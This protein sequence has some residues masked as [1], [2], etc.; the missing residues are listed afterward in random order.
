MTKKS[1]KSPH[2]QS[3]P[4]VI[5]LPYFGTVSHKLQRL[6][7]KQANIDVVLRRSHT[8][9]NTIKATIQPQ[10]RTIRKT[11]RCCFR[12]Q[13][14]KCVLSLLLSVLYA[15]CCQVR[16]TSG[17]DVFLV[18]ALPS[19][20]V[21]DHYCAYTSRCQAYHWDATTR[22]CQLHSTQPTTS[23]TG[24][25]NYKPHVGQCGQ[26][27]CAQTETC[28]PVQAAT[29][30]ICLAT[31]STTS[32]SA[33]TASPSSAT[34]VP[35]V[36]TTTNT[37]PSET[38]TSFV[39]STTPTASTS[40]PTTT[41]TTT[42]SPAT[43]AN[44][45][46][47][48]TTGVPAVTTTTYA[49]QIATITSVV[50]STT[51]TT[52][53]TTTNPTTSLTTTTSSPATTANPSTLT[54]TAV[55]VV[56]TTIYASQNAT[57]TSI[58]SSTTTTIG[59]TTTSPTTSLTTTTSSPTT[60]SIITTPTTI[61]TTSTPTTTSTT[62]APT[63]TSTTTTA[64]PTT[65][66]TTTTTTTATTTTT[67]P[68]TTTTSGPVYRGCYIDD[69]NRVLPHEHLIDTTTMTIELCRI[70]CTE[71]G[72]SFFGLEV[73]VE[74]LCGHTITSGYTKVLDNKCDRPCAADPANTC[75]GEWKIAIYEV[76]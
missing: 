75:G 28:V 19:Q 4:F 66:S 68:T 10:A 62:P 50:S 74:C 31:T 15:V 59:T 41:L 3:T 32:S 5:S 21:C 39:S 64:T 57:I 46:T 61:P 7:K 44:P 17:A 13:D 35:P 11:C 72:Y 45:S 47:L 14:M 20:R 60:S 69:S 40:S 27:Q 25:T 52:G 37:S 71:K 55:P 24:F 48:T 29:A 8:I 49:S 67:T 18:K 22:T 58:V 54:T 34:S 51:T 63:T 9:Q 38:V 26:R 65:T 6:L 30:Y 2:Q 23:N 42:S 53:T 76:V 1:Q 12:S 33:T 70:H 73:G 16:V 56:T 36:A 43:T